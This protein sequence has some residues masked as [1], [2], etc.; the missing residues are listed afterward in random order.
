MDLALFD[1]DGTIT[2]RGTYPGFIRFAIRPRRKVSAGIILGPLIVGYRVGLVSDRAI[3]KAMSRIV[4]QGEQPDRLLRLG[5]R[6]AAE[7]LTDLMRP[8]ALERIAWH[9]ARGDRVVV[10][11]ASLDVYLEPWC[12][13]MGVDVICTK[14][15]AHG[16]RVTGRYLRGDCCG[17]EKARRIRE[18]YALGEYRTVYGY[19]DTEEDR[20]MLELADKKFFRWREVSRLPEARPATR[21]GDG[22]L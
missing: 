13:T 20:E 11:S 7:A 15:E 12:A 21:R 1:F 22:R 16:G 6:Y 14:L 2:T 17:E 4:F 18:R 8:T 10:V 19:G 3:R 9:K 5:E